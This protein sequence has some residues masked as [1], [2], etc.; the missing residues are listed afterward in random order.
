MSYLI[1]KCDIC[2]GNIDK[3]MGK[4]TSIGFFCSN[5]CY[6]IACFESKLKYNK[7]ENVKRVKH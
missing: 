6:K 1:Y 4:S 7:K 3:T 2:K 5:N